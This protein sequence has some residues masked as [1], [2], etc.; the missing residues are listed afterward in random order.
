MDSDTA[1]IMAASKVPMLKPGEFEIWRM[2]IKQY[3][4]MMDYALWDVIENGPTLQKTQVMEDVTTFI[5][6]TFVE[7]KAQRRLEVKAR[8]TLMMGIPN[9]HQLKFNSI[10][11]AKQ[12][13]GAIKKRFEWN[14]HDV[15]W[16]NKADLDTMSMY[17]L[18]NN[19]KIVTETVQ[20]RAPGN[21]GTKGIQTTGSGVNNS[22]KKVI[23]Y[24]CRGEGH[25][26]RQCKEPKCARNSQ[27]YHDKALL[28]QVKEKGAVLDAEAKAF[29]VDVESFMA[30]LSSIGG[31]NGSSSSHI[32]EIV[33][34]VLWYLDSGCSRHMTGDRSKLINYVEKFIGTVR[35]EN[36]QFAK[37][38]G[39]GDYKLDDTIISRVYYVE[40]LNHKLF[41]V[42]Q[43]C[44]GGLEVAFR[45][46]TCHI[47]NMDKVD[48][49]QGSR[50]INL[51]SI[52]LNDMLSASPVFLLM[53]ASSTKSWL[54]HRRLNHLNFGTL[55]EL[56]RKDLV[57]GLPLLKFSWVRFLR[58]MDETP[59]VFLKFLKNT[60]RALNATVH[61]VRTDN[62]TE[63]VNKTLTD[64][65][66]SVG[67]T[68]QTS[69][70]RSPQQKGVV[71][72]RNRTLMEAAYLCKSSF[73][74]MG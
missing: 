21:T 9:E 19:L 15:V 49:L 30:N 68:H 16:R 26:A 74:P 55:N 31:T 17:D 8:S 6:I 51:Y 57:R 24:N 52:S 22:G 7:D 2:R 67:I 43:F 61:T 42:G 25:V 65:F 60:Q 58:T 13:M 28:M 12:L 72:R 53:K 18:Y 46:H 45:H 14:T 69:V 1:H 36:D 66:E 54:W 27:W 37:I 64:L 20:R 34:I 5:P 62:G 73:V 71:K 3:I 48:L 56:A 29:L 39:Y 70:P 38:V 44:D 4:Q 41:S 10:K 50:S 23:C 47:Q 59:E 35:F 32:N 33:Q 11:D 63:F 40:G